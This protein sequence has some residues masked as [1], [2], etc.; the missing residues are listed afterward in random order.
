MGKGSLIKIGL[1][2]RLLEDFKLL[3]SLLKDYWKGGYR[4]VSFWS[5]LVFVAGILYVI[6]PI[7]ILPDFIPLIGQIDDA[8]ILIC[9][10]WF[11]EKDLLKYKE[12]KI[13]NIEPPE[14]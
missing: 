7:D 5:I 9:C 1:W 2:S 8:M 13:R 3:Y 14:K 10:I 4:D 6:F 11:L 12:W